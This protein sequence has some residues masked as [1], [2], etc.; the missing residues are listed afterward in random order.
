MWGTSGESNDRSCEDTEVEHGG[1]V[2][3]ISLSK[4]AP[5]EGFKIM[6]GCLRAHLRQSLHSL[7]S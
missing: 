2:Y 7:D 6:K 1:N 4:D 5:T 3:E